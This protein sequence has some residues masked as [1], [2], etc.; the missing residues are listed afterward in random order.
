MD[1]VVSDA[2]PTRPDAVAPTSGVGATF[3][4]LA[5]GTSIERRH[6]TFL[7]Q[8]AGRRSGLGSAAPATDAARLAI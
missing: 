4:A 3:R 6:R 2:T 1:N 7:S 5:A 8:S